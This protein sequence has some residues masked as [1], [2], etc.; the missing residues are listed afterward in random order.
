MTKKYRPYL[1]L[2]NLE[3]I[4]TSLKG[5]IGASH[6]GSSTETLS[7][8]RYIDK[9]IS[10]IKSGLRE[11]NHTLAPSMEQ[12]L[13]FSSNPSQQNSLGYSL[14]SLLETYSS[15]GFTLLNSA[16]ITIILEYRYE[17]DLMSEQEEIQYE[18]DMGINFSS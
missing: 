9:Y 7:L 11:S 16:Q 15:T 8:I 17:N 6:P 18:K 1:T 14:E 2:P 13:G 10:D 3:V 12:K 4:S 5:S